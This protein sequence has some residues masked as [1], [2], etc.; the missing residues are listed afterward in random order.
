[1]SSLLRHL[2]ILRVSETVFDTEYLSLSEESPLL[3]TNLD[4]QLE[5]IRKRKNFK[6]YKINALF[7]KKLKNVI[8]Q[9]ISFLYG[10]QL[11]CYNRNLLY[12]LRISPR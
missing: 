12:E 4:Q 7:I 10:H 11:E 6:I 5:P 2:P 8:F 9:I 3:K 1:M